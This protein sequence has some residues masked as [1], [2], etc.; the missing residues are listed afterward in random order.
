MKNN[1]FRLAVVLFLA[2]LYNTGISGQTL[3]T[4]GS[5]STTT[6]TE[7]NKS[8]T[9]TGDLTVNGTITVP[10]GK[11]LTINGGGKKIT[12]YAPA[13]DSTTPK[14]YKCFD[15]T[16][17]LIIKNAVLDGGNNGTISNL[18]SDGN[19]ENTNVTGSWTKTSS[20][21]VIEPGGRA[22]IGGTSAADSVTV[23]N[24]YGAYGTSNTG[25]LWIVGSATATASAELN[26]VTV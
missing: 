2:L 21:I 19:G 12:V 3:S 10:A 4:S 11:T 24:M 22:S 16:G 1:I 20:A 6:I 17:I 18:P 8:V 7:T 26:H 15:V 9:L 5:W 14:N 23:Q 25:F 13:H